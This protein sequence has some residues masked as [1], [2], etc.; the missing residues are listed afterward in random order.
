MKAILIT[1]LF[2]FIL[3]PG[4]STTKIL[5]SKQINFLSKDAAGW[6]LEQCHTL[7]DFYSI[8]NSGG[9]IYQAKLMNQNVYVRALLLNVN[10][11]MALSRKEVIE[12]R[13]DTN[14]YYNILNTYLSEFLNMNYD[15]SKGKIIDTS[16]GFNRGYTFKIYFENISDPYEPIFLPDGYSYFFLENLDGVYSRVS[17]VSGLYVEDY[18]QLDGYL[19][20][21]ITFSPFSDAG[22]RLFKNKVLNESYRLVL[23]GLQRN[24]IILK[25]NLNQ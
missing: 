23:N 3:L 24:P 13:L 1:S 18:F 10:S 5:N 25:W 16:E 4:C 8:D 7:I 9:D 2:I 21:I 15:I 20:A 17:E 6:T 22:R 19:N 12:K 11:I 14:E